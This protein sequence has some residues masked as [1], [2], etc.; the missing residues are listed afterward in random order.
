MS[1]QEIPAPT[2]PQAPPA[3]PAAQQPPVQAYSV[4]ALRRVGKTRNPWGAWGLSLVTLGVYGLYWWFKVNEE[5]RG[6][7]SRVQVQPGLAVLAL[8]VPIANIVS[9][10]RTG[11][12]IA[13]AQ[14]G[15][16]APGRCSGGLG[17]LFGLLFATHIVYYQGQLNEVWAQHGSQAPGTAV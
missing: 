1:N 4:Q 12:R 3:P 16:G 6:Y 13:Q 7:D 5:V 10:V 8:F 17:F 11:G 2:T 15:A 14:V 9:V